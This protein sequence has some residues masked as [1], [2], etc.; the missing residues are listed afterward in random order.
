MAQ[1]LI[2]NGPGVCRGR[3]HSQSCVQRYRW[4]LELSVLPLGLIVVSVLV[5]GLGGVVGAALLVVS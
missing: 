1:S 5:D 4:V 3:S 2:R